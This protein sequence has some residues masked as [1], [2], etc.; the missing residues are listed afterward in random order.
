[1]DSSDGKNSDNTITFWI[2]FLVKM[3]E[4]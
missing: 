1:M 4:F 3:N 2:T